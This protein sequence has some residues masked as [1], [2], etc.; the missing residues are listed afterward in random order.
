[1]IVVTCPQVPEHLI[2]AAGCLGEYQVPGLE[3]RGLL[4]GLHP[5]L[6]GH[7][8]LTGLADQALDG[9]QVRHV[10]H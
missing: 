9:H 3:H 7:L 5:V 4:L 6:L 1:M 8:D 10:V 2:Y